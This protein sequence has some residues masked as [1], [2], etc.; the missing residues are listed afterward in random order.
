MTQF[1]K[2]NNENVI[3]TLTE[4]EKSLSQIQIPTHN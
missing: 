3:K 4:V 1:V 2:I